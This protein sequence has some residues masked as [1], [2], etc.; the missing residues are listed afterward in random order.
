M[1]TGTYNWNIPQNNNSKL[2]TI[3]DSFVANDKI[4]SLLIEDIN[5][6]KSINS[7][8]FLISNTPVKSNIIKLVDYFFYDHNN[9]LLTKSSYKNYDKIDYWYRTASLEIHNV[10]DCTQPHSLS[11]IV[12]LFNALEIAKILGYTHFQRV[13]VDDIHQENSLEW[14]KSVPEFCFSENKDGLFYVN[15]QEKNISFHYFYC[16]IDY[17]LEKI[18]KITSYP[19][20]GVGGLLCLT[21]N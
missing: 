1:Q 14:I 4:E 16:K 20:L 8:I 2:V 9:R 11:V 17:F 6:I 5:K 10:V 12:N 21:Q 7:D 13:E 18:K 19:L 3:I 15:E